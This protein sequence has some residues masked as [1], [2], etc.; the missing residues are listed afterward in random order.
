MPDDPIAFAKPFRIERTPSAFRIV[1]ATG[2]H[3]GIVVFFSGFST[4]GGQR[5][6]MPD[7]E[8]AREMAETLVKTLGDGGAAPIQKQ[9]RRYRA[10]ATCGS[11]ACRAESGPTLLCRRKPGPCL[12]GWR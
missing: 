12:R 2:R 1:D 11:T 3:T 8:Q 6:K 5:V 4:L 10:V 9:A 7:D